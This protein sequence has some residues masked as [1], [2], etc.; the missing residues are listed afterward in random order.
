VSQTVT[1]EPLN[2]FVGAEV[3]DVDVDR[4]LHDDDLPEV[5]LATLEQHGVLL[6]RGL[7][8][9][10]ASH[11]AFSHRL[12]HVELLGTGEHPEIFLVTL[13]PARNPIASYLRGTFDWHID[14]LT[15]DIPIKA[16]LLAAHGVAGEGGETEFASTYAAYDLLT[17]DE[18]EKFSALRV[19]HTIEAAQRRLEPDPT[20]EQLAMWRSRPSK[21]QPLVWRHLDGRRS[22]VLGPTADHVVGMDPDEGRTLLDD[23]LRRATAPER[24]YRHDWSVGDMVIWDNR[25]LLHRALPYDPASPRDMHR[26]TLSGDEQI[27]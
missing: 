8:I 6:F 1:T 16:T 7:H 22:V 19:V 13:D 2:E 26:T 25:G 27:Q 15:D 3:L 21:E 12:G 5:L 9:D 18:K 14:G 24:V 4:M 20:D 23:V 17:D 11:A 10:D